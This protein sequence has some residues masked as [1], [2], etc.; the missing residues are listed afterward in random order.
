MSIRGT[1]GAGPEE[2]PP[3]AIE[4]AVGTGERWSLVSWPR[5]QAP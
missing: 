5:G 2:A 1:H 4:D 3:K